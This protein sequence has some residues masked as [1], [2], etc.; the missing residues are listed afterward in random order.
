MNRL[1]RVYNTFGVKVDVITGLQF[2]NVCQCVCSATELKVVCSEKQLMHEMTHV[3]PVPSQN[4]HLLHQFAASIVRSDVFL[5]ARTA[6]P[7][8]IDR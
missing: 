7:T 4:A 2:N 8:A 3:K 1:C 5:P 6:S